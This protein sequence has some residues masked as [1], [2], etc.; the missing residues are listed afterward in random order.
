MRWVKIFRRGCF[1]FCLQKKTPICSHT[2]TEVFKSMLMTFL[3]KFYSVIL[4]GPT[5]RYRQPLTSRTDA[6]LGW[7]WHSTHISTCYSYVY[8]EMKPSITTEENEF[9]VY[10]SRVHVLWAPFHKIRDLFHDMG[11]IFRDRVVLCGSQC[12]SFL[13]SLYYNSVHDF[14]EMSLT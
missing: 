3:R 11:D 2:T 1:N 10:S 14:L 6:V 4:F 13:H 5:A 9:V 12:S 7:T 8:T